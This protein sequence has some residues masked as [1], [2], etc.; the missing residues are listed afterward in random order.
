MRMLFPLLF[1]LAFLC[2]PSHGAV[3]VSVNGSNHTIPQTNEK[4]W[5]T[6][7]T[8]WI[9]AIST[10]TL[11]PSGGTFT[12]TAEV[13]TG[14]TYGFKVPYI[15]TQT[16][17]PSTAGVLRL[18]RTDGIGWRNQ[19]N[20]ANL[21]LEVDSSNRLTFNSVILPTAT[22]A[23][24]QDSTF[25]IYDNS[26]TT[27]LVAFQVSGVTTGTTRTLTVPDASDTIAVLA[28]TQTL[29]NKTIDDD[30][31]TIQDLAVTALKTVIGQASTFLSFDG[32]GAPIATKAVPSGTVVGHTDTQTLTNKTIDADSNTLSNIENA[33]IKAAAAIAVNK[34][35]ALT[36]SRIVQTDASGFITHV[37]T[38][39]YP[40]LTELSYVKGVTSAIQTQINSATTSA[41]NPYK[42]SNC[43]LAASVGSSALTIAL[44]DEDGSDPA[45]GSPCTVTFR[46]ATATTGTYAD[47]SATA[48]TSVVV[49]NGSSLGCTA[50]SQCVL[51]VYAVND[52]GTLVLGVING[53]VLDEG[54]TQSSTTEGAAGGA[55][56]AYVLYTTT[57]VSGKAVR[58]LGRVTVTPAASHAWT[59]AAAEISNAPLVTSSWY[60][61]ANITG[62]SPSLGVAAVGSYT[63]IIDGGLTMT[64]IS[65]SAPVGTMCS[66]TNAATAPTTGTSTCAAGS[67]SV[68]ANFAIP[69]PGVYEVCVQS[70]WEGVVDAGERIDSAFELIETP[71]N[72]QTLTLEGGGRVL[73]GAALTGGTSFTSDAAFS[74]CGVFNWTTAAAGTVKGVRLMYEQTVT[75]TPNASFL[76]MDGTSNPGQYALHIRARRY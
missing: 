67:E 56:S 17:T 63:E 23:S 46:N 9:Q 19:A 64:P 53:G 5:G 15:K 54:S 75:G 37:D 66:T 38:A 36:A 59:N 3:T 76:L 11:Q 42:I 31:N 8:A 69:S 6:N 12:L 29:T 14:A 62:A 74:V 10:Y 16:A 41:S 65:G 48:A 71:T 18:A 13:D 70:S 32:T 33:D 61:N 49:S 44:K 50:S 20:G 72:A 39:T 34:L 73:M 28:A 52:A 60:V 4:G 55:D 40:T 68:G 58:L 35:A 30:D 22:S 45:G 26:D 24:V 1:T 51:Y 7:V 21:L 43:S 27:K 47:V 2:S 57:G 25:S